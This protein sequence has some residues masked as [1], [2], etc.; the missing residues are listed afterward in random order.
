MWRCMGRRDVEAVA[1]Q[2]RAERH[3]TGRE[4]AWCAHSMSCRTA[5]LVTYTMPVM[6]NTLGPMS[7]T[8]G[9]M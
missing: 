8:V 6:S 3:A 4:V 5:C 2:E 1:R 7:S 9:P